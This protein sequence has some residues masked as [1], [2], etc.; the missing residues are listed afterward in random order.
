MET[1]IEE[2]NAISNTYGNS[3][4]ASGLNA[5]RLL[6]FQ[7]RGVRPAVPKVCVFLAA[8]TPIRNAAQFTPEVTAMKNLGVTIIVVAVGSHVSKTLAIGSSMS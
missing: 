4:A 3:N 5:L 8:N 1:T 6:V 7:G 2:V